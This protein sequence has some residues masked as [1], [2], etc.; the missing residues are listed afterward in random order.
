MLLLHNAHTCSSGMLAHTRVNLY[1]LWVCYLL[2][3]TKY[4]WQGQLFLPLT[5][6]YNLYIELLLHAIYW[7]YYIL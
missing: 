6:V 3:S 1:F 2:S 5:L 7:K 4:V